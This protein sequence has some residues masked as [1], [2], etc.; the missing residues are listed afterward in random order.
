VHHYFHF[1]QLVLEH[2]EVLLVPED[3]LDLIGLEVLEHLLLRVS[4]VILE[5]LQDL[6]D[7]QARACL[8]LQVYLVYR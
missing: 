2:L 5:D 1:L 3:Q 4:Q 7:L 8:E 6:M